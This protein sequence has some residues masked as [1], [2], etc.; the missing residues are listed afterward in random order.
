MFGEREFVFL[1]LAIVGVL[2]ASNRVRL[3]VVALLTVLVL[4]LSGILSVPEALARVYRLSSNKSVNI[5][6]AWLQ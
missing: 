4:M 2:F 3:D 1:L 5:R 6:L